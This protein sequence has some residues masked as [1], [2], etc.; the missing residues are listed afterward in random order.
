MTK[1]AGW[2]QASTLLKRHPE[3]GPSKPGLLGRGLAIVELKRETLCRIGR[4]W[5]SHNRSRK[6]RSICRKRLH[7][8]SETPRT[9]LLI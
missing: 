2:A 9:W 6:R 3:G 7:P 8:H 5:V 4:C 1:S